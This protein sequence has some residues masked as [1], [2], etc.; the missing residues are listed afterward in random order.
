MSSEF[1]WKA[2][3]FNSLAPSPDRESRATQVNSN[4]TTPDITSINGCG[5]RSFSTTWLTLLTLGTMTT[6]KRLHQEEEE[7]EWQDV[8]DEEPVKKKPCLVTANGNHNGNHNSNTYNYEGLY[9][10]PAPTTSELERKGIKPVVRKRQITLDE[11]KQGTETVRVYADGIFDVFHRGHARALM[12][13]KNA[14]PNVYLIVGVCSDALTNQ[15]K[16]KLVMSEKER[17][18]AVRHCRY[19]DEVLQDAP[20]TV[21]PEFLEKHQI[22][23]VAHDDLP[24]NIGTDSTDIYQHIKEMGKFVATQRTEGISTSDLIARIVRDYDIYVRRNLERGYSA[25]DLN[26]SYMKEKE[27]QMRQRLGSLKATASKQLHRSQD[28]IRGFMGLFGRDGRISEFF[29]GQKERIKRAF[30]SPTSSD[31]EYEE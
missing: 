19:V 31:D 5:L 14:F 17:Y 15:L 18:D 7:E 11:A 3:C 10:G 27:V 24:Y 25:K 4:F 16:G 8:S 9:V 13:A 28:S 12:Q 1:P 26:V 22:D 21:T 29:H 23:F 6:R 2:G 20:W 30:T